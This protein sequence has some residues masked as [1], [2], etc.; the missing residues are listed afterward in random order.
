MCIVGEPGIGKTSLAEQ[1]QARAVE[2][3]AASAWGACW[4]YGSANGLWPWPEIAAQLARQLGIAVPEVLT[5]DSRAGQAGDG[6]SLIAAVNWLQE[7]AARRSICIVLDDLQWAP[8]PALA[9]LELLAAR[10][11]TLQTIVTWRQP[12]THPDGEVHERLQRIWRVG[13]GI[14]LPGLTLDDVRTILHDSV[15]AEHSSAEFAQE[16]RVATGGN[17]FLVAELICSWDGLPP[18]I[19][20]TEATRDVVHKRLR[21]LDPAA[22]AV[23]EAASVGGRR[24]AAEQLSLCGVGA[25]AQLQAPLEAAVRNGLLVEQG[26]GFE[27]RHD[28]LREGTYEA[29]TATERRRLH[30]AWARAWMASVPNQRLAPTIFEHLWQAADDDVETARWALRAADAHLAQHDH[31]AA[32]HAA[33]RGASRLRESDH[34]ALLA[35]LF[36]AAAEALMHGERLERGLEMCRE[37]ARIARTAGAVNALAR[38]ALGRGLSPQ[39][40]HVDREHIALLQEA[41]D[42]C[43]PE[44][45]AITLRLQARLAAALEPSDTPAASHALACQ[46]LAGAKRLGDDDCTA[47][48]LLHARGAFRPL[49]DLSERYAWDK[50]AL[51][52]ARQRRDQFAELKVLVRLATEELERGDGR[53]ARQLWARH[54]ALAN[55]TK[56]PTPLQIA[57]QVR[58]FE[59]TCRAEPEQARALLTEA[60]AQRGLE[61]NAAFD[62]VALQALLLSRWWGNV[63]W[64][65]DAVDTIC[66][67][68]DCEVTGGVAQLWLGQ[69]GAAE[70][71]YSNVRKL[72]YPDSYLDLWQRPVLCARFGTFDEQ[73]HL[74]D[75]LLPMRGQHAAYWGVGAVTDGSVESLLGAL[76]QAMQDHD[77]AIEHFEVAVRHNEPLHCKPISE[78][79]RAQLDEARKARRGSASRTSTRDRTPDAAREP[80]FT[81]DAEFWSIDFEGRTVRMADSDGVR[82]LAF[83]VGRPNE[84]VH[85]LELMAERRAGTTRP[86][87]VPERWSEAAHDVVDAQALGSYRAELLRLHAEQ[88]EAQAAGQSDRALEL[89]ARSEQLTEHLQAALGLGGRSRTR[90]S[91][92]ERSRVNVTQRIRDGVRRVSQQDPRLGHHLDRCI[93]T[94]QFCVYRPAPGSR[95]GSRSKHCDS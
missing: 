72:R 37:A 24:V 44:Q 87:S 78:Y 68:A 39:F 55:E 47:W 62:S 80:V 92:A 9:L 90:R 83:L 27:F 14:A 57:H 74:Y 77:A 7:Q 8:I 52:V 41:I 88:S 79:S 58:A 13:S 56:L 6:E 25:G 75:Y 33:Q 81:R 95:E 17:P 76:A 89:R 45:Q 21:L 93:A 82:Y 36:A 64:I 26:D 31:D 49:H 54:T 42:A 29:L 12:G 35:E 5:S 1:L 16:V 40:S 11:S 15:G 34:P 10:R 20:L 85:T 70:H 46:A 28:L 59:A 67:T 71:A 50:E 22:R 66:L 23:V 32:A 19:Q 53:A 65:R 43:G 69:H 63:E 2:R 94:G 84:P 18:R 3:G 38:T 91:A 61:R 30:R 73:R 4:E 86:S 48:V 60:R 51:H